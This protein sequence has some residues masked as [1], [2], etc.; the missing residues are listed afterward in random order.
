MDADLVLSFSCFSV[1]WLCLPSEIFLIKILVDLEANYGLNIP[2]KGKMIMNDKLERIWKRSQPVFFI[3]ISQNSPGLT[4]Q[5]HKNP[6]S[7]LGSLQAMN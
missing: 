6:K 4:E 1:M 7:K 3:E 2:L 5:N